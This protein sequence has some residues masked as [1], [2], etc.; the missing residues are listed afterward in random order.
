[1]TDKPRSRS[2]W[3]RRQ[4]REYNNLRAEYSNGLIFN[5]FSRVLDVGG[6]TRRQRRLFEAVKWQAWRGVARKFANMLIQPTEA[7]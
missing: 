4:R 5:E 7:P 3:T 2:R 6:L 1:M